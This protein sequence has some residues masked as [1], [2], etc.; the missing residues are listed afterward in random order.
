MVML[1][2]VCLLGGPAPA[3]GQS[4]CSIP[5]LD[6]EGLWVSVG[7]GG[8]LSVTIPTA[9][10]MVAEKIAAAMGGEVRLHLP[11]RFSLA[12]RGVHKEFAGHLS[13]YQFLRHSDFLLNGAYALVALPHFEWSLGVALGTSWIAAQFVHNPSWVPM[14]DKVVA[15][16]E[17]RRKNVWSFTS[18]FNTRL[19]VYPI[20][21]LELYLDLLT[22]FAYQQAF[23]FNEGPLTL[24]IQ[25]GLGVHF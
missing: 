6:R 21:A 9:G 25:G 2:A 11:H 4:L 17:V 3:R 7:G 20:D 23:E 16:G 1:A 22:T 18:G 10:K 5:G 24:Q 14:G 12:V 13:E 8:G 15:T 19:S